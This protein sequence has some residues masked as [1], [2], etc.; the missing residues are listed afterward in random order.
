[1]W[2]DSID[3]VS[4]Q[5][6]NWA[7]HLQNIRVA[8]Q[9][10][11]EKMQTKSKQNQLQIQWKFIEFLFTTNISLIDFT[12]AFCR[13]NWLTHITKY[14]YIIHTNCTNF[15]SGIRL[16]TYLKQ[17]CSLDT[18]VSIYMHMLTS[19]FLIFGIFNIIFQAETQL[20]F[21]LNGLSFLIK[22]YPNKLV[23]HFGQD[24]Q[25]PRIDHHIQ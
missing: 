10:S 1:M 4:A 18:C 24:S 13:D 16:E 20:T 19:I 12:I 15:V 22:H 5:F 7:K 2:F 9:S 21:S 8:R 23:D 6:F 3:A 11:G 17:I 25:I 14:I